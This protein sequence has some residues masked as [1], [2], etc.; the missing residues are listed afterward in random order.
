MFCFVLKIIE[1]KEKNESVSS[2]MKN[3]IILQFTF[4]FTFIFNTKIIKVQSKINKF[5]SF[6]R[7]AIVGRYIPLYF[8]IY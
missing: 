8:D 2:S 6:L 7:M 5:I 1:N 4:T 3:K